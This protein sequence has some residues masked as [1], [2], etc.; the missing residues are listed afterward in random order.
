MELEALAAELDELLEVDR[1]R[2]VDASLNGLQVGDGTRSVE[3]VALSVDAAVEPI[4]RAAAAAADLLVAHHGILWGEAEG[5][6]RH[7]YAR[8]AAL[9]EADLALYVAHLPLDGHPELGHAAVLGGT[10]GIVDVEP[11]GR[12]DGRP[13]GV[14]GG[15]RGGPPAD[16]V[17][18]D[19]ADAV[20]TA[21]DDLDDIGTPPDRVDR[22]A[23]VTGSGTDFV[24]GAAATDADV[25]VTGEAKQAAYHR[26]RELGLYVLLGGHYATERFGLEALGERLE[27]WGLETT[28]VDVPTG[29]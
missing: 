7:R 28:F 6:T 8:V 16:E 17:R 9:V 4:E 20:G 27:H 15:L 11:F 19:L 24:E 21:P 2:P 1:Y 5:V 23:I 13:T 3:H 18:R 25:L 14:I 22:V 10:L 12:I 26:A 29:I